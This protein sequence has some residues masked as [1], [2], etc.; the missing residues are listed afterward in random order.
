MIARRILQGI[1]K[2]KYKN[3]PSRMR[4]WQSASHIERDNKD[5]GDE[6]PQTA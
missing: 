3:N 2:I 5:E 6:T 4:A 1:M